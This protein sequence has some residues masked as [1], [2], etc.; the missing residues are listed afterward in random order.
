MSLNPIEAIK[1]I[2]T[3]TKVLHI[4]L[5]V[6]RGLD[7]HGDLLERF[8]KEFKDLVLVGK[9]IV[10]AFTKEAK[11]LKADAEYMQDEYVAFDTGEFTEPVA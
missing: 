3:L 6:R 2:D 11:L 1:G 9:E 7:K 5:S 10:E 4:M 8:A